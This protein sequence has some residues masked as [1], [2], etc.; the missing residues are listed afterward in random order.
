MKGGA[1]V[2]VE[3]ESVWTV[4]FWID[5]LRTP[6]TRDRLGQD[7]ASARGVAE[8]EGSAEAPG[9]SPRRRAD[10]SGPGA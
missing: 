9:V 2:V 10:A 1:A 8:G 6:G 3:R 4:R 7:G 5:A